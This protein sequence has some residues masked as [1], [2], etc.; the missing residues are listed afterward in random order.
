MVGFETCD[1][2]ELMKQFIGYIDKANITIVDLS[3]ALRGAQHNCQP[4]FTS[5]FDFCFT[6]QN[7]SMG[8]KS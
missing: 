2:E 1:F 6:T 5:D 3:G 8:R 4:N 7:F